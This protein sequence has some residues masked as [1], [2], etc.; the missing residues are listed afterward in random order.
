[1]PDGSP[2]GMV[3]G[4]TKARTAASG[5]RSAAPRGSSFASGM[6]RSA[7]PPSGA[8]HSRLP[9]GGGGPPG[10]DL[11]GP[12]ERR[13]RRDCRDGATRNLLHRTG[14]ELGPNDAFPIKQLHVNGEGGCARRGQRLDS[15]DGTRG[16]SEILTVSKRGSR[17]SHSSLVEDGEATSGSAPNVDSSGSRREDLRKWRNDP[18]IQAHP[19]VLDVFDGWLPGDSPF[20]P[21]ARSLD[22][23]L[24][25]AEPFAVQMVDP[26]HLPR[27]TR[28][29]PV[30]IEEVVADRRSY[31]PLAGAPLPPLTRDLQIS[32]TAASFVVPQKVRFRYKLEDHDTDLV[33]PGT[34]RQAFYNDPGPGDVRF[35]VDR[36]QQRRRL[37]RGRGRS[38][39]SASRRPGTRRTGF[40]RSP[41]SSVVFVIWALYRQRVRQI[42]AAIGVRFD[43]RLAERT[44]L[45]R[46]IHDTLLQTLQGSKLVADDALDRLQRCRPNAWSLAA[47]V[48]V[49]A[50]EPRRK[51]GRH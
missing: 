40:V 26:D 31:L 48:R 3:V 34:R 14:P 38:E 5:Q 6:A 28:P 12:R 51:C 42:E 15:S 8:G 22:G 37:E 18:D 33:E 10:R 7:S 19:M 1:M 23:R 2:L 25:F 24:W 49:A 50:R 44:R 27:N 41:P 4:L 43:E 9:A 16:P 11:V 45:A 20:Q 32:Y 47:A 29:P 21:A 46:D 17:R 39:A 35:R 36:R 30:H 13:S